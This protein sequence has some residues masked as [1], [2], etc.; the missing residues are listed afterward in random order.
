[1]LGSH[2]LRTPYVSILIV[3]RCLEQAAG[4]FNGDCC[5][6]ERMNWPHLAAD[7]FIET[8]VLSARGQHLGTG[9]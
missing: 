3:L 6:R 5:R 2:D 9:G 1:M 8:L 4:R 7:R